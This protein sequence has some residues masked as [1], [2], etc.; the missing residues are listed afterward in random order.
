MCD[1]A[2]RNCTPGSEMGVTAAFPMALSFPF[3]FQSSH[4]LRPACGLSSSRASRGS[5]WLLLLC[6]LG[7]TFFLSALFS[8]IDTSAYFHPES[9]CPGVGLLR[10]YPKMLTFPP[11]TLNNICF[12]SSPV[13]L[14]V[15]RA[16]PGAHSS[17]TLSSRSA[18][19][20]S[21]SII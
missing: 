16:V 15:P 14:P 7:A 1:F 17:R 20:L 10:L 13:P 12:H 8:R 11:F 18:H 19:F 21:E 3:V 6:T 5:T 2:G 4:G 9:L